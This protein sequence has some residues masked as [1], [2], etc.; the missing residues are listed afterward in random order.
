MQEAVYELGI[1]DLLGIGMTIVVLVI[2]L[3]FGLQ[4]TGEVKDDIAEATCEGRADGYTIWNETSGYCHNST[5][6]SLSEPPASAEY[7]ATGE[8][9]VAVAKIP[10]K[11]GTI[12]TVVVAAILIGLLIRYLWVRYSG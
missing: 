6:H 1:Q 5:N 7:N 2:G 9:I 3:A 12:I 4:I 8:G 11:L 10:E